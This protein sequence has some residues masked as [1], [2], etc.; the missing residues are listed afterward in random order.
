MIFDI[1]DEIIKL[2]VGER[3]MVNVGIKS[4]LLLMLLIIIGG[5]EC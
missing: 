1:I 4:K 2:N 5:F 3:Y